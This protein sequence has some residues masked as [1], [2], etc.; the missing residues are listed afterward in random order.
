[1]PLSKG[2]S[3]DPVDIEI[4]PDGAIWISSW[5]RQYGAHFEHKKLA[6]EGRIYRLW[7]KEFSPADKADK[8]DKANTVEALIGQLGSHLPVWRSNAQ[9]ELINRGSKVKSQLLAALRNP[10]R[11]T[12]H[13][14][15]LFWTLGRIN[16]KSWFDSTPNQLIQSIRLAAFNLSLIHI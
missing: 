14:T 10:K 9:E 15:W 12:A 4:G 7:P 2:R 3:F 16:P 6:N 1:M 8:A 13:E 5:G 11:T